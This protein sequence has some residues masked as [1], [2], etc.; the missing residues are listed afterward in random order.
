MK[1]FAF[2]LLIVLCALLV[3]VGCD[4]EDMGSLK[5]VTRPY[6]G[7]YE[8]EELSVG[9]KDLREKFEKITL[10]L[11]PDGTFTAAYSTAEGSGASIDG[12]YTLDTEKGE[13]TLSAK[14]GARSRAFTFPYE[15]GTIRIERNLFGRLLHAEFRMPS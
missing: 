15:K 2:S 8:C 12:A 3:F 11:K 9:G 10:E 14:Q 6:T 13:I 4:A 5:D 7:I 1:K